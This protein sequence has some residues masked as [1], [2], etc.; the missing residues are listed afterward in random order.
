[1][2]KK[3]T[4]QEVKHVAKLA[5]LSL[6]ETELE[7]FRGKLSETL[8]YVSQLTKL[9]TKNTKATPQVTNKVNEFR[10]D[11]IVPGL[12]QAEALQNARQTYN[13]YFV[14]KIAWS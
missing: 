8:E 7:E 6:S 13:G 4:I 11:V 2:K 5:N 9:D 10:E 1:M 12:S 14:A 3:L